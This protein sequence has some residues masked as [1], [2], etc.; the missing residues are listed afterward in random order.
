MFYTYAHYTPEGRLFYI[1]KGSSV[2]RAHYMQGRNNYWCKVVAKYG[3]PVVKILAEWLTE[4]EAFEHEIT[5]I[6]EYREQGLELCNLTDGGDGTSGYK[7]SDEHRQKNSQARIG[8][9]ATWNI[10][11]K[12]TEETKI[13]CGLANIGKPSSAKQKATTSAMLQGNTYGA[14]NTNNRTWIWIGTDVLTGEVV[15]F[16]G[17]KEMKL[18]GLQHSNIIKCLNGERKSHK[19]YTWAR[20]PWSNA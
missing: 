1:G 20:E 10:G 9:S 6:K 8:K 12:H 4:K 11:R 17:E 7:Q 15:N 14:G 19:G 18:A 5:L 3:K 16:I 2:R 13:K